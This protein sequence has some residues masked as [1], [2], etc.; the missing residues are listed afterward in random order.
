MSCRVVVRSG[1]ESLS[2]ARIV[3]TIEQASIEIVQNEISER[4][5]N[6]VLIRCDNVN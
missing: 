6:R 4:I 1:A 3:G 2:S 5:I